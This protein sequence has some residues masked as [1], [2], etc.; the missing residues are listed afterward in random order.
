V[1]C[2]STAAAIIRSL[3]TRGVDVIVLD[4]HQVSDPVP[5]AV[6]LVNPQVG[7]QALAC[8]GAGQPEARSPIFAELCSVGLAFKLAHALVKRGREVNLPG[9][10]EMDLRPFLD[11]VALGTIAD[12]VPLTGE[13]RILVAAGLQRLNTTKRAGLLALKKVAQSPMMLVFNSRR[14]LTPPAGWKQPR[15]LCGCCWPPT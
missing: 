5:E 9:A 11:L 3:R 12:L 14:A 15:H 8:S 10:A 1:D 13:N 2:G 6:A 7:V 4:H